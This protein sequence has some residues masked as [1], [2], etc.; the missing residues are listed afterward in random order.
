MSPLDPPDTQAWRK[1]AEWFAKVQSVNAGPSAADPDGHQSA[2]VAELELAY[3]AGAW[4]AVVAL[5]WAIVEAAAPKGQDLPREAEW[6]RAWRNRIVHGD[7]DLPA[8]DESAQQEAAQ[9]AVRVALAT[10]FAAA[11]R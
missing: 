4:M 6:L 5:A 9:G 1:R 2:L 10:L 7:P 11:W 8:L 3:C